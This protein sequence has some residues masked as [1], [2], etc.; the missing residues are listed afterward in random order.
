MI[1]KKTV[2]CKWSVDWDKRIA[3]KFYCKLIKYS[4]EV[5][6]FENEILVPD[7]GLNFTRFQ[8]ISL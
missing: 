5:P 6:H 1:Y 3:Y 2:I 8:L 4:M 7:I